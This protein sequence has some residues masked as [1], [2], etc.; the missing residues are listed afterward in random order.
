[1][2]TTGRQKLAIQI[3]KEQID[4]SQGERV[5]FTFSHNLTY[6]QQETFVRRVTSKCEGQ[7][8]STVWQANNRLRIEVWRREIPVGGRID[9]SRAVADVATQVMPRHA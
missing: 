8:H 7:I 6:K 4:G 9:I 1:M 3:K 2:S 5:I